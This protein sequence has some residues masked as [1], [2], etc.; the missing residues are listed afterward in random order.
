MGAED[1]CQQQR[2]LEAVTTLKKE[3]ELEAAE[4]KSRTE[5]GNQKPGK[6]YSDLP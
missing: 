6:S 2:K 4:K 3:I 1:R 5:T